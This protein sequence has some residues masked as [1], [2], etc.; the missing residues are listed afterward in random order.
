MSQTRGSREDGRPDILCFLDGSDGPL[1]VP[2]FAHRVG[3][4]SAYSE[5]GTPIV[6]DADEGTLDYRCLRWHDLQQKTSQGLPDRRLSVQQF[7]DFGAEYADDR[8]KDA[9]YEQAENFISTNRTTRYADGSGRVALPTSIIRLIGSE[10]D[11]D[12]VALAIRGPI[13]GEPDEVD[14]STDPE[15][16]NALGLP[17]GV[18]FHGT[19]AVSGTGGTVS[20]S[21]PRVVVGGLSFFGQAAVNAAAKVA[22]AGGSITQIRDAARAAAFGLP[23]PPFTPEG[24]RTRPPPPVRN[25]DGSVVPNNHPLGY[26]WEEGVNRIGLLG[27]LLTSG[28]LDADVRY[29]TGREGTPIN[30]LAVRHDGHVAMSETRTGRVHYVPTEISGVPE[31][32]GG[33]VK[34]WM[35]HDASVANTATEVGQET[36]QWR[37]VVRVGL[38]DITTRLPPPPFPP[39]NPPPRVQPDPR[40]PEEQILDGPTT[41]PR[42]NTEEL[43]DDGR[44]IIVRSPDGTVLDVRRVQGGILSPVQFGIPG[45]GGSPGPSVTATGNSPG[46]LLILPSPSGDQLLIGAA[47]PIPLGL[48]GGAGT[49]GPIT[50]SGFEGDLPLGLPG[51]A[52]GGVGFEPQPESGGL[53]DSEADA[54]N[55]AR[56]EAREAARQEALDAEQAAI[57]EMRAK[58]EAAGGRA[59]ARIRAKADR[60]Q[61]NR[62][63]REARRQK[64]DDYKRRKKEEADARRRRREEARRK[65]RARREAAAASAARAA[66]DRKAEAQAAGIFGGVGYVVDVTNP[67]AP[68]TFGDSGLSAQ[69]EAE[70][71]RV[72]GGGSELGSLGVIG[73]TATTLLGAPGSAGGPKNLEGWTALATYAINSQQVISSGAFGGSGFLNAPINVVEVVEGGK[74]P[75]GSTLGQQIIAASGGQQTVFGTPPLHIVGGVHAEK[76]SN[77]RVGGAGLI[78]VT[79]PQTGGGTIVDARPGIFIPPPGG[80]GGGGGGPPR[81]GPTAPPVPPAPADPTKPDAIV[82]GEGGAAGAFV[83]HSGGYTTTTGVTVAAPAGTGNKPAISVGVINTPDGKIYGTPAFGLDTIGTS[84]IKTTP[85]DLPTT[86]AAGTVKT[87]SVGQGVSIVGSNGQTSVVGGGFLAFGTPIKPATSEGSSGGVGVVGN[88]V[89]ITKGPLGGV[90]AEGTDSTGAATGGPSAELSTSDGHFF[91]GGVTITGKLTVTGRI[92]PTTLEF[93]DTPTDHIPNGTAGFRFDSATNV[94]PLWK[95]KASPFTQGPLA[96]LSDV[97]GLS[98][99]PWASFTPT[100][101]LTTNATATGRRRREG[102]DLLLRV[103]VAFTGATDAL[104]FQVTIP[105]TVDEAALLSTTA[106]VVGQA[107]FYDATGPTVNTGWDVLYEQATNKNLVLFSGATQIWGSTPTAFANGDFVELHARLPI[108]GWT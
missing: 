41:T 17:E 42:G 59:G 18:S 14:V 44:F 58:G 1:D 55:A 100:C 39:P 2:K 75:A 20:A 54:A 46:H 107:M 30:R 65:R 35:M 23:P 38:K 88:G 15:E 74:K 77:V 97:T 50:D 7:V 28:A 106:S 66:D 69:D 3:V 32:D 83:V 5:D 101:S 89:K 84:T 33:M 90:K 81:P 40:P 76:G 36:G 99:T 92:D 98:N 24:T 10:D 95:Q 43:S 85:G 37:P 25:P 22:R 86:P 108:S 26:V 13:M 45:G 19:G 29:F 82:V 16:L 49:G 78:T 91:T 62:D 4:V 80:F 71:R 103:R 51:G 27:T 53:T 8:D 64:R 68:V 72:L 56:A 48:P 12:A 87:Y 31:G 52:S 73:N 11:R 34:G 47:N 67:E 6:K 104:R 70:R 105:E 102:P 96:L 93:T 63:R 9:P 57:N 94:R 60:L 21:Q 61:R 79:R